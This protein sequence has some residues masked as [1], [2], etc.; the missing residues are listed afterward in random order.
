MVLFLVGAQ[1]FLC[2]FIIFVFKFGFFLIFKSFFLNIC[3]LSSKCFMISFKEFEVSSLTFIQ[4][5]TH[6]FNFLGGLGTKCFVGGQCN[7]SCLGFFR[8]PSS[9]SVRYRLV[10]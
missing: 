8:T 5:H 1:V 2:F 7:A 10:M 3:F 9:E 6:S 4:S